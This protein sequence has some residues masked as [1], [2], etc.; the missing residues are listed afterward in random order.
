MQKRARAEPSS[1][2]R[3][4]IPPADPVPVSPLTAASAP[5]PP[6]KTATSDRVAVEDLIGMRDDEAEE[7]R[8]FQALTQAEQLLAEQLRDSG[9]GK[10]VTRGDTI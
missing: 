1:A 5:V 2:Q 10:E 3:R 8:V 4:T 9:A 6:L 7:L